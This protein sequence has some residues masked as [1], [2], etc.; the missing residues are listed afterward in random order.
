MG[1]NKMLKW[2]HSIWKIHS[3]TTKLRQNELSMAITEDAGNF[4]AVSC[5]Q[6]NINWVLFCFVYLCLSLF[7]FWSMKKASEGE[8]KI[9]WRHVLR[10][11]GTRSLCLV[12]YRFARK[13]EYSLLF[14]VILSATTLW[15]DI[16]CESFQ[17]QSFK[18]THLIVLDSEERKNKHVI[19]IIFHELSV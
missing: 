4:A 1:Q 16:L 12:L 10:L 6:I 19:A 14:F 7:I 3:W 18:S 9:R 11:K 15:N 13:I 5:Y 2:R 8:G 17:L